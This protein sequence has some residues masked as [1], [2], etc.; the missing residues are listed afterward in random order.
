LS[1]QSY[2]TPYGVDP[3]AEDGPNL[4][5][6][7][8]PRLGRIMYRLAVAGGDDRALRLRELDDFLCNE[9]PT[10]P[11]AF[12]QASWLLAPSV[13]AARQ[14]VVDPFGRIALRELYVKQGA[15]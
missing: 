3:P 5:R 11:V 9:L 7:S 8:T 4:T 1:A 6:Y 15:A 13:H 2:V 14:R 12:G 10:I